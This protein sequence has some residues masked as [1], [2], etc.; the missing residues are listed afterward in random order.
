MRLSAVLALVALVAACS[1]SSPQA[2]APAVSPAPV[3]SAPAGG[4]ASRGTVG[5]GGGA[6]IVPVGG[7]G[8]SSLAAAAAKVK[9]WCALLPND[10][11]AKFAPG[12]PPA[13]AGTYPNECGASNGTGALDFQLHDRVRHVGPNGGPGR[14]GRSGL[15]QFAYIDRPTRDEVEL[16]VTLSA[17]TGYGLFIDVAG[18]DGKDHK[19]DA[20]AIAEA[21][22]GKLAG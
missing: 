18:H 22:L 8:G 7:G 21:V 16:W 13:A 6:S 12:A 9:D 20:V 1:G 4:G 10:V 3:A 11:I 5:G 15:A 2:S 14:R 19:A 17:D